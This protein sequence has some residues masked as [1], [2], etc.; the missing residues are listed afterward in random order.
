[1]HACD[2]A[3]SE[4]AAVAIVV[5]RLW[6]WHRLL[7]GGAANRLSKAEQ[8]GLWGEL[9]VLRLHVSN[10][11]EVR[12]ALA[13]WRG[14]LG[15]RQDFQFSGASLEVKTVSDYTPSLVVH[16]EWQFVPATYGQPL[17]LAVCRVAVGASVGVGSSSLDE[18]VATMRVDLNAIPSALARFDNLLFAAGYSRDA[19]YPEIIALSEPP[20]LFHVG[21]DFPSITP[22]TLPPGIKDVQ[23]AID[24]QAL[25]RHG[26]EWT[27]LYELLA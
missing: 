25:R 6:R 27:T 20:S 1:M 3:D 14:P 19:G 9:T 15:E 22:A 4:E 8:V 10:R 18:L 26:T 2:T 12:A 5:Q 23:Y 16:S 13:S 11:L 24:A 17:Y 7:R 21:P